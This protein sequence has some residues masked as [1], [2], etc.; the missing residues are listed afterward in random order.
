MNKTICIVEDDAN[1]REMIRMALTSFSYDVTAFD[2]AEDALDSVF[3]DLPD[4]LIFDI[5]LP[6]MSGLEATQL[7]RDNP[8][9]KDLPIILLTAKDT[10]LDKVTGL[11][12]GADDYIAKPFGVMELGAR[13]RS[14]LRRTDTDDTH[15]VEN[16]VVS[17]LSINYKTREV[18]HRDKP[19]D[20]TFKEY[21][22]LCL[23]VQERDRIVPREELLTT[24]WGF[25][26][27]GESR[28]LDIHVRTLRQKLGDGADEPTYIKTVRNVGYRF[29]GD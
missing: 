20:L 4:L 22:L 28:T 21:E 27:M 24:I 19:L 17:D 6:G 9:T 11:D 13:I 7:I 2:N 8:K 3:R 15:I 5:M 25:E 10:E 16:L 1:I 14:L 26:F 29:I 23:L 12:C 18:T